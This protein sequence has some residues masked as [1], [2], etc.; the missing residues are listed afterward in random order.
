M[1]TRNGRL[2]SSIDAAPEAARP[3]CVEVDAEQLTPRAKQQKRVGRNDRCPCGSGKKFKHCCMLRL[4]RG[5][6]F[7]TAPAK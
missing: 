6:G 3:Y 1:D 4:A 7:R 2:Y 5:E